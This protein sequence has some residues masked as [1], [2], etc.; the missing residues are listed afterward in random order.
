[1]ISLRIA[2]TYY[3]YLLIKNNKRSYIFKDLL[4]KN[5][6]YIVCNIFDRHPRPSSI[7][8]LDTMFNIGYKRKKLDYKL[9]E[10]LDKSQKYAYMLGK[11]LNFKII[12]SSISL[13]NL[14]SSN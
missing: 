6:H 3:N 7:C 4:I 12:L 5:P 1:M 11:N 9:F 13:S 8:A 14:C 2:N 10:S